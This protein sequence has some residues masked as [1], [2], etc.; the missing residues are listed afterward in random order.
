MQGGTVESVKR[1]LSAIHSRI[2]QISALRNDIEAVQKIGQEFINLASLFPRGEIDKVLQSIP[3][4]VD[5]T[6]L[7]V[8]NAAKMIAY[9][10]RMLP[11]LATART[12]IETLLGDG[13]HIDGTVAAEVQQ[14]IDSMI[15]SAAAEDA[16]YRRIRNPE[17]D[18]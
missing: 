9:I 11:E 18:E 17:E 15:K 8:E 14:Y 16:L 7:S 1:K 13:R 4:T 6:F 10:G 2:A 12:N 5:G 3:I